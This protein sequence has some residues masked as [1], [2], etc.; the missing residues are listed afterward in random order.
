MKKSF[1]SSKKN[2]IFVAVARAGN[3]IGG[4]DLKDN[5]IVPDIYK[6]IQK[7]KSLIIRNPKSVR[8]WQH[9][10]EPLSGYLLFAANL[11]NS[12]KYHGQ[13]YNFGPSSSQNYPV[14]D[15]ITEMS[16][17]WDQVEWSDNSKKNSDL[18]EAGLLKLN[19]DK[20]L[21]DLNW[22]PVLKFEE[23]V[24]MTVEWYKAYYKEPVSY[25]HL[26]LPTTPY[27]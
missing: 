6:S 13:A 23:T 17:Y 24:K 3:V 1:F 4:G 27:V 26:T 5:R 18:Y 9:V 7:N 14:I 22:L 12:N 11:K 20:A 25:T 10:L 16:K 15:L 8:P 2:N 21:F 19:C